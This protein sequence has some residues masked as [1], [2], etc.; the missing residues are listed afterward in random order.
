MANTWQFANAGTGVPELWS[1]KAIR[2]MEK[3]QYFAPFMYSLDNQKENKNPD[4]GKGAEIIQVHKEFRSKSG[5]RVTL[6][7]V[8]AITG[9]A[10]Y[11][12]AL[13][14]DTGADLDIF[15]LSVFFDYWAK[16][17]RTSG[18]LSEKLQV[19]NFR[20]T[21]QPELSSY[22]AIH[23]EESILVALN[24]LSSWN[25]TTVLK[26]FATTGAASSVMRN[27]LTAFD[28]DHIHFCGNAT[29]NGTVDSA[30]LLTAQELRKIKTKINE[31]LAIPLE[32][33]KVDGHDRFLLAVS[34]RGA[35]QLLADDEF[36]EAQK[37]TNLRGSKNPLMRQVIGEFDDFLVVE[38]PKTLNPAA[39]VG[40]SLVLGRNALQVAEVEDPRWWEGVEDNMERR[41]VIALGGAYGLVGSYFNS[42][43][44]NSMAVR[45]YVRT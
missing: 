1:E 31:D 42:T 21:S 2:D 7:N 16:Q 44:R 32:P 22:G 28:S 10:I 26:N 39:N 29:T 4:F 14:R 3:R 43:V 13:L 33:F 45:H 37:Y 9:E 5:D 23:L 18:P 30:D 19:L 35:E 34:G 38:F 11:G 8:A 25:N 6:M 17:V 36:R 27:T 12:D 41:K 24:R 15:E 40:Q 20:K